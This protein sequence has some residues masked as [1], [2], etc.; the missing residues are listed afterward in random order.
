MKRHSVHHNHWEPEIGLAK[1]GNGKVINICELCNKVNK[2]GLK[3]SLLSVR[4]L[5]FIIKTRIDH[6]YCSLYFHNPQFITNDGRGTAKLIPC[7]YHNLSKYDSAIL[8]N[9]IT[10]VGNKHFQ[11]IDRNGNVVTK[12]ILKGNTIL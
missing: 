1:F 2:H 7:Y 9:I 5:F 8:L 3:N 4:H 11:Q 12:P 6:W 10:R